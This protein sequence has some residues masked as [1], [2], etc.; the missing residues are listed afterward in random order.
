METIKPQGLYD[1]SLQTDKGRELVKEFEG[2]ARTIISKL[3]YNHTESNV[4]QHEVVT[5]TTYITNPSFTD[6]W[7]GTAFQFL[8]L[9]KEKLSLLDSLIPD[10]DKISETARITFLQRAVKENHDVRQIHVLDSFWRSKTGSTEKITFE[11]W[12]D[13][14]WNAAYQHD[15]NDAARHKKSQAFNFQQLDSFDES[16]PD[17]DEDTLFDQEEDESSPYYIFQSFFNSPVPQKPTMI[18]IPNNP[19]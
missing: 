7:K 15:L 1:V 6:N 16:D 13:S 12:Y 2:E 5:L 11:V 3:H 8:S 4:A 9:F 18:F 17:P 10:T 19:W 14:L